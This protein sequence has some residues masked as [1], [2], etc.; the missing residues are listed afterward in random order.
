ISGEW[1]GISAGGCPNHPATYPNNPKFLVTLESTRTMGC[2]NSL[3]VFLKGPKQYSLGMKV[4]CVKLDDET[5]TAPF[6]TKDS[7]AYRSG[8]VVLELDS[9]PS[10][11]FEITPSTFS[12]QQ[13]GPFFLEFKSSCSIT[14]TRVR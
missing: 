12:P 6:K 9:L 8:F 14:V 7:G 13:E 3:L 1:K 10:G 11:T 4:T 5:M 2:D